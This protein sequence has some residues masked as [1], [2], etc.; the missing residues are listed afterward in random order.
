M[1]KKRRRWWRLIFSLL[2][3]V[4]WLSIKFLPGRAHFKT[5]WL[6]TAARQPLEIG[7]K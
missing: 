7:S 5:L 1:I 4:L 2:L 6:R 3:R